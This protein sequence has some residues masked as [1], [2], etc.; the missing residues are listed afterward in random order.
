MPDSG[1]FRCYDNGNIPALF[2]KD[3]R[4]NLA[5]PSSSGSVKEVFLRIGIPCV[6]VS[7]A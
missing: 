4:L 7:V 2:S 3:S 6:R 5:V 1:D